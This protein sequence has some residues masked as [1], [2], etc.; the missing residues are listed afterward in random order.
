MFPLGLRCIV[1]LATFYVSSDS[2]LSGY[3]LSW[4]RRYMFHVS[5]SLFPMF[6]SHALCLPFHFLGLRSF[7]STLSYC[8]SLRLLR[9]RT[10]LP[11]WRIRSLVYIF[12]VL[13][14]DNLRTNITYFSLVSVW[15]SSERS[16]PPARL[17]PS[18]SPLLLTSFPL[19]CI[20]VWVVDSYP[21]DSSF[22][23]PSVRP[24]PVGS[25]RNTH[26]S[27]FFGKI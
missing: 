15:G 25:E 6:P 4:L 19:A 26:C 8:T 21:L 17:W 7:P 16:D 27:I 12:C 13:V 20:L 23:P 22:R 10:R 18:L 2:V 5:L 11:L 1:D 14:F 9:S 3:V 24:D